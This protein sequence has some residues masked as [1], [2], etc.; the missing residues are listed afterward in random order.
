MVITSIHRSTNLRR[1]AR[2]HADPVAFCPAFSSCAATFRQRMRILHVSDLH[3]GRGLGDLS[4]EAEQRA[5]VAEIVAGAADREVALTIVSGDVF[6]AFN[7]PA[8]AEDLFF[9][10]LDGLAAGGRRAVAVIA[11]N[12]DSGM[13]LAA[14]D[15]LARRLGI[16]LAGDVGDPLRGHDG[17]S[18]TVRVVPLAPQVARLEV[19]GADAPIVLG[20]M[21]FLSE[22]RVARE[23]TAD[24][25]SAGDD[26]ARYTARLGRDLAA[27]AAHR[28]PRAVNLLTAHQFVTGGAGSDSERRLRL[29][30]FGDID[31]S[32]IPVGLDYVALG[33]L[34]RPQAIIG[35]ASP[36][37]YAGSP[38]A[39]SFSEAGQEK[40]AVL[41][42]ASPG[43]AAQVS[44][45]PL[46]GGRP[47]EI[48]QVR[49]LDEARARAATIRERPPI[50][51]IRA[52]L[53][54]TLG[55]TDSDALFGIPGV[56][57]LS[58][59]DLHDPHP[60]EQRARAGDE[61]P[62]MRVEELFRDLWAKKHGAPP[63]DATVAELASALMEVVRDEDD[64]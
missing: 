10:L 44:D 6:D 28:D 21:P 61:L 17:A 55:V 58:V 4:R 12:H 46:R 41:I 62:E 20:L 43:R 24:F 49:T 23:G 56:T 63:D 22:A 16:L 38:I 30:A 47:L 36:T 48:W 25:A 9:E 5:V 60:A 39:Y 2:E 26:G 52:D 57:V 8:W 33:H 40:R 59:R 3:L 45:V 50:V 18:G 37:F 29:A 13:R 34:H 11:G 15:P 31:A 42:D 7:P 64:R 32:A 1:A 35:A 14:A 53:G 54:H 51:E 19:P 27:R